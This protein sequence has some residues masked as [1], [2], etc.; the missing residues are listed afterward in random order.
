MSFVFA[1]IHASI[2]VSRRKQRICA[3]IESSWLSPLPFQISAPMRLAFAPIVQALAAAI[4]LAA[5]VA[6][7]EYDR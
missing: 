3:E 2:S 4:I 6:T 7:G 1:A 5:V